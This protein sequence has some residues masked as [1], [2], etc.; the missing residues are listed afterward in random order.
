[1]AA[2]APPPA[3]PPS[4]TPTP[5]PPPPPPPPPSTHVGPGPLSEA[6]AR[7]VVFATAEEFPYLTAVFGSDDEAVAAADQLLLR[8]IWHLQLAGYQAGRQRNPSG[9]I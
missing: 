3:P 2:P 6:R 4:P 5:P 8:T 1:P 9:A 7:Q